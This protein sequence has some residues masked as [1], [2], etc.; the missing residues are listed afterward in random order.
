MRL[1]DRTIDLETGDVSTGGRL[2]QFECALVR[3]LVD[4]RGE[5]VGRDELLVEV[6]GYPRPVPTRAVDTAIRRVRRKLERTPR[7]PRHLMTVQGRGYRWVAQETPHL[8]SDW[9]SR[10][11]RAEEVFGV[12]L[13]LTD[14]RVGLRGDVEA[15]WERMVSALDPGSER[16]VARLAAMPATPAELGPTLVAGVAELVARGL[17]EVVV[18]GLALAAPWSEVAE[19]DGD[20]RR[21]AVGLWRRRLARGRPLALAQVEEMVAWAEVDGEE[22][23]RLWLDAVPYLLGQPSYPR[24]QLAAADRLLGGELEGDTRAE[25]LVARANNLRAAGLL[26]EAFRDARAAIAFAESSTVRGTGV[27]VMALLL[28][29]TSDWEEALVAY[30]E[31]IQLTSEQ[32][33]WFAAGLQAELGLVAFTMGHVDEAMAS[34]RHANALARRVLVGSPYHLRAQASVARASRVHAT[35]LVGLG[36]LREALPRLRSIVE[37]AERGRASGIGVL[38]AHALFLGHLDAGDPDE[39]HRWLLRERAIAEVSGESLMGAQ[40]EGGLGMWHAVRGE[41][42]KA[43]VAFQR[44][45]A[46]FDD[47]G[48]VARSLP[49]RCWLAVLEDDLGHKDIAVERCLATL[50]M[51]PSALAPGIQAMLGAMAERLGVECPV[52]PEIGQLQT[53]VRVARRHFGLSVLPPEHW[54]SK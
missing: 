44:C 23:A 6:W 51:R 27:G 18:D 1:C 40:I 49:Y 28:H 15:A 22:R 7:T 50:A 9:E 14:P 47:A 5:V 54:W 21:W 19:P 37:E 29:T 31:A 26:D 46:L 41:S 33:P 32:R 53:Y 39:A 24:A 20:A 38:A 13:R 11:A 25:L 3:Y 48:L 4:R 30:R 10:R 12:D 52:G 42:R 34:A 35:V 43:Q 17:V 2:T 45:V 16:V 36:R 8:P